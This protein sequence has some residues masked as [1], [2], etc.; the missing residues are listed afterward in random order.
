MDRYDET[1]VKKKEEMHKLED[2]KT[3]IFVY[4]KTLSI[5]ERQPIK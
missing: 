1:Q 4:Q 2:I 3:K 5:G